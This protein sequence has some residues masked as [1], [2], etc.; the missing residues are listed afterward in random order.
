MHMLSVCLLAV[1]GLILAATNSMSAL[2]AIIFFTT[3]WRWAGR[4][5]IVFGGRGLI[6]IALSIATAA[7]ASQTS[8][9][10][11]LW[12]NNIFTANQNPYSATAKGINLCH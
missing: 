4:T 2:S 7:V 9:A 10:F 6:F 8:A 5:A 11:E 12:K 1:P 3:G